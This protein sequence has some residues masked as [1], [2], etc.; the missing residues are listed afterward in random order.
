MYSTIAYLID[1]YWHTRNL[2]TIEFNPSNIY[3]LLYNAPAYS[4]SS[5]CPK[6]GNQLGS[7]VHILVFFLSYFA[8]VRSPVLY[9]DV[10]CDFFGCFFILVFFNVF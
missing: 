4:N 2:F 6:L 1:G 7:L 3:V 5:I 8:L 10:V 9:N